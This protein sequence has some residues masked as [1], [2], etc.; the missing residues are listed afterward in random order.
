MARKLPGASKRR[1]RSL[2]VLALA[3][4]SVTVDAFAQSGSEV[5]DVAPSA[6]APKGTPASRSAWRGSRFEWNHSATT[7]TLGIGRDV[8]TANPTYE[9]AF[10]L[11]PRYRVWDASDELELSVSLG[12]R[13]E[14]IREFTNS[15]VTTRR[16]EW[17]FSN[18]SVWSGY[19]Y[20]L[21]ERNGYETGLGVRAPL[22]S[23]P[24]S[25]AS[26]NNGTLFGLG[27][28][29]SA[30]QTAPLRG[31]DAAFLRSA[32]VTARAGYEHV[33]RR[34]TTPTDPELER[35]RMGPDLETV[36]SDQ[37][38]GRAF[39]RHEVTLGFATSL[40]LHERV[41][42]QNLFEWHLGWKYRFRDVE[43][44]GAVATGPAPVEPG[45]REPRIFTVVALFSSELAIAVAKE[46]DVELGY[47]N[48]APQLG[49]DGRRRGM[50]HSTEARF[51]LGLVAN[52]D[53]LGEHLAGDRPAVVGHR[54]ASR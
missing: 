45:A 37:L 35:E 26:A 53:A 1:A 36:P 25:K 3:V 52:L 41:R 29:V 21:Y 28:V 39:T 50:F 8:Q 31:E 10:A 20:E 24:T 44:D 32:A 7:E 17:T 19:A 30:S 27:A 40:E 11:M 49:I 9:M 51:T 43:L 38:A 6:G 4:S 5:D 47:Q 15:D 23:F 13:I 46:V 2:C 48:L 34:A 42:W 14:L 33:F 54:L 16:G 12:S 22:L 18:L